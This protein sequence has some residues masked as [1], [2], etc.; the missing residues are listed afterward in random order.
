MP[1]L[2]F[3][4]IVPPIVNNFMVILDISSKSTKMPHI[5]F[6]KLKS[7][8]EKRISKSETQFYVFT[9]E[10]NS[11]IFT[12]TM[13]KVA[14]DSSQNHNQVNLVVNCCFYFDCLFC[15]DDFAKP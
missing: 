14:F 2:F 1:R 10:S 6:E 4:V 15:E 8:K 7:Q 12:E 11:S 13:T 5:D 9:N 3:A